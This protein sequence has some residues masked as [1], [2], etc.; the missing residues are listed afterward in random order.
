LAVGGEG[1]EDLVGGLGSFQVCTECGWSPNARQIREIAD[2][3]I[4]VA[5]AIDRVDQCVSCPGPRSS[6]VRVITSSTCSSVIVR[7]APGRGSSGRPSSRAATNRDRHFAT[8]ARDTPSAAATSVFEDGLVGTPARM[9]RRSAWWAPS[10]RVARDRHPLA[11]IRRLRE[12]RRELRIRTSEC[13]AAHE[14]NRRPAQGRASG[15]LAAGDRGHHGWLLV[16]R[17]GSAPS[18]AGMRIGRRVEDQ[19]SII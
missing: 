1:A 4:P 11:R 10:G 2:W 12:R 19:V 3:L 13:S 8:V 14:R 6:S 5:A 7:G 9:H 16:Q 15:G 17:G 18:P